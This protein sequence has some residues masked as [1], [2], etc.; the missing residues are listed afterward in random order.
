L[1]PEYSGH[2][3]GLLANAL[4]ILDNKG[5]LYGKYGKSRVIESKPNTYETVWQYSG[6]S[7]NEFYLLFGGSPTFPLALISAQKSCAR[8]K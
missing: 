4:L 3:V 7:D 8:A 6:V 2:D 5:N 1:H